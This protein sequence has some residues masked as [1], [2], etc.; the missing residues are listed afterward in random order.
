LTAAMAED[1]PGPGCM[2]DQGGLDSAEAAATAAAVAT[3]AG[4]AAA[5]AAVAAATVGAFASP[6]HRI[7]AG[8]AADD[9]DEVYA[10]LRDAHSVG[11]TL[12][13]SVLHWVAQW[14]GS[15]GHDD[16]NWSLGFDDLPDGDENDDGSGV[17]GSSG[18]GAAAVVGV[19]SVPPL[20]PQPPW[21]QPAATPPGRPLKKRRIDGDH[22]AGLSSG[23]CHLARGLALRMH[24]CVGHTRSLDSIENAMDVDAAQNPS[25]PSAPRLAGQLVEQ[26][27]LSSTEMAT[28]YGVGHAL[29][30]RSSGGD[31]PQLFA[32]GY[33][34]S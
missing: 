29:L 28:L 15:V 19:G 11:I 8:A 34:T 20:S 6:L 17:G 24:G 7:Q 31:V 5:A 18:S 23:L 4:A 33:Q 3:R 2:P 13:D 32:V 10:G 16:L 14:L 22:R 9:L 12:D 30:L 26:Q 25:A 27:P 1:V 21:R